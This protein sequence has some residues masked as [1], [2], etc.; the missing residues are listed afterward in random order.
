M[1]SEDFEGL[2]GA[3]AINEIQAG[4]ARQ[5]AAT[6]GVEVDATE[7]ARLERPLT[8]DDEALR[9]YRLG[10]HYSTS[11]ADPA[12]LQQAI[13]YF[14]QAIALD[15]AFATAYAAKAFAVDLRAEFT[16]M[17]PRDY[18]PEMR[19]LAR[20]A[21]ELDED[22][23]A[24]H[25]QLAF[26]HL[27]YE[28]DWPGAE[29]E[30]RRAIELDPNS[31]EP[32]MWYGWTLSL[33]GRHDEAVTEVERALELDPAYPLI[34]MQYAQR[35]LLARRYDEALVEARRA[36]EMEPGHWGF[37]FVL[38]WAHLARGDYEEGIRQ[39]EEARDMAPGATVVPPKLAYA[40]GMFGRH[41]QAEQIL[42]QL[43]AQSNDRYLPAMYFA[44]AHLGLGNTDA[45]FQWLEQAYDEREWALLF[46]L[47]ADPLWDSVRDDPRL[48]ELRRRVGFDEW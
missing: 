8:Q 13:E 16:G 39:L 23:A 9:L 20:K 47:G 2:P 41:D 25:I 40:Y 27:Q 42:E 36:V 26:V 6:L 14:D 5:V 11:L 38:A 1:W 24:A 4:A 15:S 29:R 30:F 43:R 31:A 28:F 44:E 34:R 33:V 17:R 21:I 19:W 12:A 18:V 45:V 10:R 22:N 35:L 3:N 37:M 46:A 32:H 48:E 7:R